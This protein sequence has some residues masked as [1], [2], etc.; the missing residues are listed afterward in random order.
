MASYRPNNKLHDI[1]SDFTTYFISLLLNERYSLN[2]FFQPIPVIGRRTWLNR[3]G[4]EKVERM[5]EGDE[6]ITST[7]T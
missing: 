2:L 7:T 6:N 3:R 4:K 1:F 5:K